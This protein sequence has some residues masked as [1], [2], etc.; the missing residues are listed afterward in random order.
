MKDVAR[1]GGVHKSTV[2]LA[3]RNHPSIPEA[4]GARLRSLAREM[5]YHPEPALS[6]IAAHRWNSTKVASGLT[7]AYVLQREDGISAN[8]QHY[9]PGLKQRAEVRGCRVEVVSLADYP[10]AAA[11]GRVLFNRGISGLLLA[12]IPHMAS[13]LDL[14]FDWDKF[15][16]VCC[17]LGWAHP[18]LHTVSYDVFFSARRVWREMRVRGYRRIGP[19]LFSHLPAA[20]HDYGR[21][22]AVLSEQAE[23]PAADRVPPLRCGF[24]DEAAFLKWFKRHE[25]DAVMGFHPGLTSWMKKAGKRVP[26]DVGFACL[27]MKQRENVAGMFTPPTQVAEVAVDFVISCLRDNERGL[28]RLPRNLLIE[29]EW[30]EGPTLRPPPAR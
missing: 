1:R 15:C 8:P 14:D 24:G 12:P 25:P 6:L 28:P 4:T 11:L 23:L 7:L 27:Q 5:G 13:P 19:A 10:S 17:S 20:D 22:G 2:S 21:L 26:Q 29:P 3:L 9:I 30:L 18:L 16:V